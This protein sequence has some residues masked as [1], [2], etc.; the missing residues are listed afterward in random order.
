MTNPKC[1]TS[2]RTALAMVEGRT[3][4]HAGIYILVEEFNTEQSAL[5]ERK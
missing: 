4:N 5:M 2:F 3:L 1:H